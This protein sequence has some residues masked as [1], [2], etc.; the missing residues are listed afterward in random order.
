MAQGEYEATQKDIA[1]QSQIAQEERAMK[2]SLALSQ[3]Q[4]EQK[5]AQQTQMAS[6]PT[7]A[8]GGVLNQFA[9]L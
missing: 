6:D 2:N 4:F 3:M 7:T 1:M 9:E 8:I 5:L